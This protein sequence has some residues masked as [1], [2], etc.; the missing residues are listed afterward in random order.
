MY[1]D[2]LSD[3][4]TFAPTGIDPRLLDEQAR[5]EADAFR[6]E[7]YISEEELD[8]MARAEQATFDVVGHVRPEHVA[9]FTAYVESCGV[10]PGFLEV[11]I[12]GIVIIRDRQPIA[13]EDVKMLSRIVAAFR[14]SVNETRV[15][16]IGR[17]YRAEAR[18]AGGPWKRAGTYDDENEAQR[19][20][21]AKLAGL[22][23]GMVKGAA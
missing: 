8:A 15:S 9:A 17:H 10:I 11:L 4:I 13:R 18:L 14:P 21:D 22:R 19:A 12:D 2:E 16:R 5:D 6:C 7:L 23:A 20:A 1:H 3:G